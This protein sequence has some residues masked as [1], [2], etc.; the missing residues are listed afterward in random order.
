MKQT[1]HATPPESLLQAVTLE[2]PLRLSGVGSGS[3]VSLDGDRWAR[4]ARAGARR[5]V[6][7]RVMRW[8]R[9]RFL[10]VVGSEAPTEAFGAFSAVRPRARSARVTERL[11]WANGR[12]ELGERTGRSRPGRTCRHL[13]AQTSQSSERSE[14]TDT[15]P[16]RIRTGHTQ[17]GSRGE[18]ETGKEHRPPHST[19]TAT[20]HTNG[21]CCCTTE[22]TR[23]AQGQ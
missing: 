15:G 8:G 5:L 3:A 1:K 11:G 9:D 16:A 21:S 18:Y 19:S 23:K 20:H 7:E 6:G 22:A 13:R 17:R 10:R 4:W 2:R 12:W 14:R